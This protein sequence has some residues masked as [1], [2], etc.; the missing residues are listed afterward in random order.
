M[1]ATLGNA[2]ISYDE[3]IGL[4]YGK[5]PVYTEINEGLIL[6]NY[7]PGQELLLLYSWILGIRRVLTQKILSRYTCKANLMLN[8]A[9]FP[10]DVTGYA[11]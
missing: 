2:F 6:F 3:P 5:L 8:R 4:V 9:N 11:I 1:I 7:S 10:T